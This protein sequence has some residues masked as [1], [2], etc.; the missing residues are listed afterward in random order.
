MPKLVEKRRRG[1]GGEGGRREFIS[2]I[3]F[4]LFFFFFSFA[5]WTPGRGPVPVSCRGKLGIH[6]NHRLSLYCH[7]LVG[8]VGGPKRKLRIPAV[9]IFGAGGDHRIADPS[10]ADFNGSLPPPHLCAIC[11]LTGQL[12]RLPQSG[13]LSVGCPSG[14]LAGRLAV[15]ASWDEPVGTSFIFP[16][17]RTDMGTRMAILSGIVEI[18]TIGADI[19]EAEIIPRRGEGVVCLSIRLLEGHYQK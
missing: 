2:F 3:Y 17:T 6:C 12:Q 8:G 18:H 4:F 11:F 14:L 7:F 16:N 1:G 13:G 15:A 9:R 10:P 19:Y 5:P